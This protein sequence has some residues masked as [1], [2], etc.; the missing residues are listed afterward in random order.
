[1]VCVKVLST[2]SGFGPCPVGTPC[3]PEAQRLLVCCKVMPQAENRCISTKAYVVLDIF[4][5]NL[6]F[7]DTKGPQ[8]ILLLNVF[9][10][11]F[12]CTSKRNTTTFYFFLLFW[13]NVA[14]KLC[15][16]CWVCLRIFQIF[17]VQKDSSFW[18]LFMLNFNSC[19][20]VSTEITFDRVNSLSVFK[21]IL[22]QT[23]FSCSEIIW[24]LPVIRIKCMAIIQEKISKYDKPVFILNPEEH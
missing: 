10:S 18:S 12:S 21:Y 11:V 3:A 7:Y 5:L 22:L 2:L 8:Y 14:F 19:K 13:V 20:A 9:T 15:L 1:M 16:N 17:L 4:I 24:S 23:S 6:S